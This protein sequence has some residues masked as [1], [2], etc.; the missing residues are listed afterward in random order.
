[1]PEQAASALH[2]F[3]PGA[4]VQ[5]AVPASQYEPAR[6]MPSGHGMPVAGISAQ[7]CCVLTQYRLSFV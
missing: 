4:T 1:V 2:G 5:V 6:Q 7:T 3:L